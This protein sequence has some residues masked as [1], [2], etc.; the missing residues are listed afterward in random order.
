QQDFVFDTGAQVSIISE[1]T[2]AQIGIFD[3]GENPT[4]PDFTVEVSGVGGTTT[5]VPGFYIN[6]LNVVTNG[7]PIT[8]TH[9][10]V[11]LLN[12]LDPRTGSGFVPG[13]LGMNLFG[14]RD[15]IVNADT[16]NPFVGLS[17]QWAWAATNGGSWSNAA[18]WKL[19]LP[20]GID[21]QANFL[22]PTGATGPQTVTVDGGGFTVGTLAFDNV[23]RYTINGPGTITMQ[24][25]VDQAQINVS[26]GNHTINAPMTLLNDTDVTVSLASSTL[27]IS[28]DVNAGTN[29]VIKDGLGTLEMKNVRAGGLS[30]NGGTVFITANGTSTG[31]SRIT[32]LSIG[33][34]SILTGKLDL[35]NNAMAIDNTGTL[36]TAATDVRTWLASGF[37]SGSWNGNGIMSSAAATVAANSGNIHK[38]AI[39]FALASSIGSPA[40]WF[41]QGVNPTSILMRYT[42]D[43]DADLNGQVG[44]TD[45][46]AL[47]ANFGTGGKFWWQGDMNYDGVVNVLDLNAI[48]TN[49]G[50]AAPAPI[51]L[52][53]LVPEPGSM[54]CVG[55]I[56]LLFRRRR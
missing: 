15:L 38:T 12:V 39:G 31:A 42:I 30:V 23:N 5:E 2:A 21:T 11:L 10:P 41:G 44:M 50:Q 17:P 55:L 53:A 54:L 34:G 32:T 35:N 22:T 33:G 29:A 3:G 56:P 6:S 14:D 19:V 4:P 28:S 8:W 36:N 51:A 26:T 1:D 16:N 52:G 24:V 27:T 47:A 40:T 49:W 37:A 13:I 20:N 7:G 48:A 46:N 9:V 25:S 43:G 45:F 18:N